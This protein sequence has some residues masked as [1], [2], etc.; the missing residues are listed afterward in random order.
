MLTLGNAISYR[1]AFNY[2]SDML[3]L[4][5]HIRRN[6]AANVFNS[7]ALL[8]FVRGPGLPACPLSAPY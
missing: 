7:G 4:G 1:R 3:S 5:Y 2:A 8:I 6:N